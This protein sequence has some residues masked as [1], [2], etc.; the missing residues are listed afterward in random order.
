MTADTPGERSI[1]GARFPVYKII[2]NQNPY[3][4]IMMNNA[5]TSTSTQRTADP[6]KRL[7]ES[8]KWQT[9]VEKF[10]SKSLF[11]GRFPSSEVSK[12]LN[13]TC[14]RKCIMGCLVLKS[15]YLA[16]GSNICWIKG[17]TQC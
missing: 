13:D 4:K 17:M 5:D 8:C 16:I 6:N 10:D 1:A 2:I 11:A 3:K 12:I 15:L 14:L 9:K 7:N